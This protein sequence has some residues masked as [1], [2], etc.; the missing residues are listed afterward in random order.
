SSLV[1]EKLRFVDE[2]IAKYTNY[3]NPSYS[4]VTPQNIGLEPISVV[5]QQNT[6]IKQLENKV[7]SKT[8]ETNVLPR[9]IW[10]TIKRLQDELDPKAEQ[11]VVKRFRNSQKRTLISVRFLLL[12]VIVPFLT[13]QLS[14]QIIVGP[15]VDQFRDREENAI[16]LNDEMEERAFVEMQRFEE[17]IKFKNLLISDEEIS[18]V[19]VEHQMKE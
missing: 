14:K 1:L 15:L 19:V 8:E 2:V 13:H 12:L 16:F 6:P 4:L 11:D 18:P 5:S 17:R 7:K 10:G 9:S 3:E